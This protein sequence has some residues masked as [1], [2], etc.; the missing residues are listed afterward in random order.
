MTSVTAS[1]TKEIRR[2]IDVV[3]AQYGDIRHH[4]ANNVHPDFEFTVHSSDEQRSEY[5]QV[6]RVLGFRRS[7]EVQLDL[8]ADGSQHAKF[9]EGPSQGLDI[10]VSFESLGPD[11][12][13]V[14]FKVVAPLRG[15][16]ALAKPLVKRQ[17]TRDIA[18]VLEEDRIDLEEL[19]Y[20]R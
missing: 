17:L 4:Q 11:S 18:N 9:V 12:T 15:L 3:R 10:L 1:L 5:T 6:S 8:R 2:P 7:D 20:P 13:L 19:G 16:M 14:E